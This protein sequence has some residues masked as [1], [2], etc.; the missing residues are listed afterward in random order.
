MDD[1]DDFNDFDGSDPF[2]AEFFKKPSSNVY[3][4]SSS[5]KKAK[6]SGDDESF[7]SCVN[8]FF[9]TKNTGFMNNII[10]IYEWS[11]SEQI[12][13]PSD[14]EPSD[15]DDEDWSFG[16]G[17]GKRSMVPQ[18]SSKDD[19]EFSMMSND[20]SVVISNFV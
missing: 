7:V 8:E 20:T 3:T 19:D 17:F 14:N 11:I 15:N 5:N 13:T 12:F 9:I 4:S 6:G 2:G 10:V 18:R 16:K 1:F